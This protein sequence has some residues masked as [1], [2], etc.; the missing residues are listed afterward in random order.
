M[1]G[2]PEQNGIIERP[3][4]TCVSPE[5]P[6]FRYAGRYE[7]RQSEPPGPS[8][9]NNFMP[10]TR[11]METRRSHRRRRVVAALARRWCVAR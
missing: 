3:A 9:E 5:K 1:I 8:A 6:L 11:R 4:H 2:S 7:R 10:E